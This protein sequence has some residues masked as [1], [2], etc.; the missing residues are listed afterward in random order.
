MTSIINLK[1]HQNF[2]SKDKVMTREKYIKETKKV[3]EKGK[4]KEVDGMIIYRSNGNYGLF[5]KETGSALGFGRRSVK[6]VEKDIPLLLKMSGGKSIHDPA[7][8]KSLNE[9]VDWQLQ[10]QSLQMKYNYKELR[11]KEK[12]YRNQQVLD[13][14]AGISPDTR[15][16]HAID[17]QKPDISW[18]DIQYKSGVDLNKDTLPYRN[19]QFHRVISYAGLGMNFGTSK[20]FREVYRILKKNGII[21]IGIGNGYEKNIEPIKNEL[22][23]SGFTIIRTQKRTLPNGGV[24]TVIIGRKHA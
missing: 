6:E 17:L 21:E 20:T 3:L 12:D 9:D 22:K 4:V 15:A 18:I 19:N 24:F 13:I 11:S 23:N 14:G 7:V 2:W 5:D 16:T 1:Y 10:Q 8:R